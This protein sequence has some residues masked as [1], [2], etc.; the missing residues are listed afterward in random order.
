MTAVLITYLS[1]GVPYFYL[2]LVLYMITKFIYSLL[3]ALTVYHCSIFLLS[4]MILLSAFLIKPKLEMTLWNLPPWNLSTCVITQY[5]YILLYVGYTY[6]LKLYLIPNI[7]FLKFI[8]TIKIV[9]N[10]LK[11]SLLT[12]LGGNYYY[13]KV[14]IQLKTIM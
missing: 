8:F 4:K 14:Y 5:S 3:P 11:S 13:T 7:N 10:R 9:F 12:L 1:P 2:C 6:L